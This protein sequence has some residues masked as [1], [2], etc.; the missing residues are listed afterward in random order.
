MLE[1]RTG[2]TKGNGRFSQFSRKGLKVIE[3]RVTATQLLPLLRHCLK[4]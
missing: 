4:H 1:G 2:M 3:N